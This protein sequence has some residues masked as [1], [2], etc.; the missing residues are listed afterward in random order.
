[1]DNPLKLEKV[2]N[3]AGNGKGGKREGDGCRE[4]GENKYTRKRQKSEKVRSG[5]WKDKIL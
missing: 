5:A 1:M 3:N 2:G 4:R